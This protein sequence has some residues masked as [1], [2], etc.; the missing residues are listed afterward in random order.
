MYVAYSNLVESLLTEKSIHSTNCKEQTN[1]QIHIQNNMSNK[2][3]LNETTKRL[4][5]QRK[6]TNKKRLFN[7]I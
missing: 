5:L 1:K 6:N 3:G 7:L 4:L 2:Y